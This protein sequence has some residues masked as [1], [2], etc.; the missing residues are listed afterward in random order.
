MELTAFNA[1]S[2]VAACVIVLMGYELGGYYGIGH[3]ESDQSAQ[4]VTAAGAAAA[5]DLGL[6]MS[7]ER[8]SKVNQ[9]SFVRA[10]KDH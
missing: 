7:L 10:L 6:L 4:R 2:T 8:E 5:D 9:A 3:A 1:G